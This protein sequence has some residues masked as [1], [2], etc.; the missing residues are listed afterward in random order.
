M[1]AANIQVQ[2]GV[3]HLAEYHHLRCPPSPKSLLKPLCATLLGHLMLSTEQLTLFVHK[4]P[5]FTPQLRAGLLASTKAME[6]PMFAPQ[7]NPNSIFEKLH[8]TANNF[9]NCSLTS[10]LQIC[11]AL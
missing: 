8:T 5:T 11:R 10:Y 1:A 3:G 7:T 4:T 9:L 2:L 6:K